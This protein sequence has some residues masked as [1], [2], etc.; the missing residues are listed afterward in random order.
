MD[1]AIVERALRKSGSKRC[2]DRVATGTVIADKQ[3]IRVV[4]YR[5]AD[6][7]EQPADLRVHSFDHGVKV[8]WIALLGIRLVEVRE[9]GLQQIPGRHV[10]RRVRRIERQP[11]QPGRVAF[12]RIAQPLDGVIDLVADGV[13][14]PGREFTVLKVYPGEIA[15][16]AASHQ[17]GKVVEPHQVGVLLPT[18][19]HVRE[20]PLADRGLFIAQVR[21][22]AECLSQ[23]EF[24]QGD[25]PP[26]TVVGSTGTHS[27]AHACAH[28][29]LNDAGRHRR[30]FRHRASRD[31][32]AGG[33]AYT[34]T[35]AVAARQNRRPGRRAHRL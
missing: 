14:R 19:T 8:A 12:G 20:M 31:V 33:T 4:H 17:P 16:D 27:H 5:C 32:V 6:V 22:S 2:P 3:D 28:A 35:K 9:I 15:L 29:E 1:A 24:V 30:G 26:A 10:N 13:P 23:R 18:V 21:A 34:G 25:P 7:I 11:Q